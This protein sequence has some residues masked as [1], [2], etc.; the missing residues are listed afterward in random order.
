MSKKRYHF[1]EE[2]RRRILDA[3]DFVTEYMKQA[4]LDVMRYDSMSTLSVYLKFDYGVAHSMR[5]SDHRGKANLTYKYNIRTDV[6]EYERRVTPEGIEH[7]FFPINQLQEACRM[8]LIAKYRKIAKY[9]EESYF[10]FMYNTQAYAAITQNR[11][12]KSATRC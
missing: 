1:T 7:N 2:D 10:R 8:I 5:I 3:A 11:F 6:T 4:G 12:W 9:G